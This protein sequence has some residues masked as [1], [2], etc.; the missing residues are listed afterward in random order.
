MEQYRPE[1][2]DAAEG[3]AGV[4]RWQLLTRTAD[5]WDAV[6]EECRRARR[7]I[8]I[9]HYIFSDDPVGRYLGD[10]LAGRARE[11][12]RVR[13]L[14]DAFGSRKLLDSRACE[15][16]RAAGAE[17][18]AYNP[19]W[20]WPLYGLKR[21]IRR[22]HRKIVVADDTA[23]VGSACFQ[24]EMA[25]WRDL[26]VRLQGPVVA[27]IAGEF[28]AIW[29][30]PSGRG[31]PPRRESAHDADFA[32]L[33]NAAGRGRAMYRRLLREISRARSEVILCSPYLLPDRGFIRA[34]ESARAR[35]AAV[36]A[37][38]PQ[39]TDA[40]FVDAV[41]WTYYGRLLRLGC[42]L[43]LYRPVVLHAKAAAVDGVW[44]TVGSMNLDRLSFHFNREGNIVS[45]D[46]SFAAAVTAELHA[47]KR[48]SEEVDLDMWRNRPWQKKLAGAIGRP[49]SP[50]L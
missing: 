17:V 27:D 26:T 50:V 38:A 28:E 4:H 39:K 32:F 18:V 13:I 40:P 2:T 31:T 47:M 22:D 9:E 42:R 15:T 7:R 43:F 41:G 20:R 46:R 29:A 11:G 34:I 36:L 14:L 23:L 49:L 45:R 8:E 5:Y 19:F 16:L 35:G 10:L 30:R 25:D 3:R 33:G 37:V 12:V 24:A 21:Q 1:E 48:S 6:A 44:A